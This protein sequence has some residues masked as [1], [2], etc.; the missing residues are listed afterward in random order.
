VKRVSFVSFLFSILV[1]C[2]PFVG[3][4]YCTIKHARLV[5]GIIYVIGVFYAVPLMFEYEPHEEEMISKYLSSLIRKKLYHHRPSSIGR[6]FIFRWTYASINA[7]GVYVIPLTIIAIIN[8]KLLIS[9][10]LLQERS[11]EYHAPSPT[12][13]GERQ[14]HVISWTF[15]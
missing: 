2:R 7:F 5:T 15:D 10:R 6:S 4:K 8:R 12:K 14:I 9:I 13:Q 3:P 1:I 11:V